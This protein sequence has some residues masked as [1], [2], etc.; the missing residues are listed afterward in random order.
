[1]ENVYTETN[2]TLNSST[3]Q[4]AKHSCPTK[5]R[6]KPTAKKQEREDDYL[7]HIREGEIKNV[8]APVADAN[9]KYKGKYEERINV[10][11]FNRRAVGDEVG[12]ACITWTNSDCIC[13]FE[14]IT[15]VL[16]P[17][18]AEVAVPH[19]GTLTITPGD[20]AE[21]F[22]KPFGPDDYPDFTW[23]HRKDRLITRIYS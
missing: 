19:V 12:V 21:G 14:V 15:K 3:K 16:T 2:T 8:N 7:E 22:T 20:L 18:K 4:A 10:F 17:L 6:M 1:M 9:G 5:R 13:L 23:S 11:K